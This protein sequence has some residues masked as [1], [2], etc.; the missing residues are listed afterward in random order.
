MPGRAR[1]FAAF[2]GTCL[3]AVAGE[4]EADTVE[5]GTSMDGRFGGPPPPD[6]LV[7]TDTHPLEWKVIQVCHAPLPISPHPRAE[8]PRWA[9]ELPPHPNAVPIT[10]TPL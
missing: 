9:M 8:W 1:A 6:C 3:T 5:H 7:H 4:W 10:R 2:L